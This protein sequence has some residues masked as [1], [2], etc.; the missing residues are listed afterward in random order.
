MDEVLFHI[1]QHLEA[2]QVYLN[3]SIQH[4]RLMLQTSSDHARTFFTEVWSG[5]RAANLREGVE[6]LYLWLAD[7][8]GEVKRLAEGLIQPQR[9][10]RQI[11]HLLENDLSRTGLYFGGLGF[12]F[13]GLFGVM[14]GLSWYRPPPPMQRM[15]AVVC[16]GYYGP[17]SLAT[18]D[19]LPVPTISSP[20]QIL[21]QVKAASVDTVDS[22][23]CCGYGRVLR[24]QLYRHSY[25]SIDRDRIVCGFLQGIII[26]IGQKVKNFEVG[27]EVWFGAPFWS[28]GTM[29]ECVVVKENMVAKKP[30]GVGFEV[31]ASLPYAGTVAWN[32]MV[33]QAG[34]NDASTAGKS[35]SVKLF[36]V[37]E[38]A[39][40]SLSCSISRILVHG[41]S[42][43]VGC[44]L[45]QLARL[46]GGSV[47]TTC[48]SRATP[49]AQALGAE[50]VIVTG[51]GNVEKQLEV[52][53][54]FDMIFNTVE[55]SLSHEACLKFCR[56]GGRV[57]TTFPS[58]IASDSYSFLLRPTYNLW[59]RIKLLL[60]LSPWGDLVLSPTTLDQLAAL[61]EDGSLQPVVDKI[62]SPQDA[63]LAF[64]HAG[65]DEAIGKT[66][67]RFSP[68]SVVDLSLAWFTLNMLSVVM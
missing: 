46:W 42:S 57:V 23:I 68:V 15:R 44:I 26:E 65:S 3:S 22:K 47:A 4:G 35:S 27:D 9:F 1:S 40:N 28:S 31:A 64:Q 50:E 11:R 10:L 24:K 5:Q 45:I 7:Q 63:E 58:H 67:I 34:L 16:T 21:V 66:V 39:I 19:D 53:E 29:C 18:V 49:V 60:G 33:H 17:D 43:P 14:L 61:V 52:R 56:P 59:L 38:D 36:V 13:G 55:G 2:L 8:V 54:S 51:R 30:R 62:F 12:L 32:A 41:G 6:Q 37:L 20:D 25:V 48:S